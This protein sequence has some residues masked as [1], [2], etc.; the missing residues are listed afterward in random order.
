MRP[1]DADLLPEVLHTA[2]FDALMEEQ[3]DKL[4]AGVKARKAM[5]TYLKKYI[6]DIPTLDVVPVDNTFGEIM[7]WAVRYALGRRTYAVGDTVHYVLPLV[8]K[9]SDLTLWVIERDILERDKIEGGLGDAC[10]ERQWRR[11]LEKV[12][13]ELMLRSKEGRH[14]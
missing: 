12:S 1:I 13:E 9:L 11:L 14:T 5:E 10:D 4:K 7:N 8:P 2:L 3:N 6:D